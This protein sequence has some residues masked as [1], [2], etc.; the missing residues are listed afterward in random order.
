VERPW[1]L[2]VQLPDRQPEPVPHETE[3]YELFDQNNGSLLILGEP[4]SG[5]STLLM[6]LTRQLIQRAEGDPLVPIP[7][8]FNLS[9]WK[10]DQSLASWVEDELKSKYYVPRKVAQEWLENDE[11]ALMLDGLDEVK[12]DY[13]EDCVQAIHVF[14]EDHVV[15]LAVCSRREAYEDLSTRLKLR[16]AIQIQPLA[17]EQVNDY[18][19]ALG[20]KFEWVR[21]EVEHDQDLQE[22]LNTPLMLS[23]VTLANAGETTENWFQLDPSRSR[24]EI[25]I[26][27]YIQQML[28]RRGKDRF[29]TPEKT[30]H[31]IQWLAQ[32]MIEQGQTI[33]YLESVHRNLLPTDR[34]K[35]YHTLLTFV[36]FGLTAS[37]LFVWNSWD[38]F[39]H[40]QE[41]LFSIYGWIMYREFY[42]D[43]VYSLLILLVGV[44]IIGL[45]ISDLQEPVERLDWSWSNIRS[46]LRNI[47][48]N[49]FWVGLTFWLTYWLI[50]MLGAFLLIKDTPGYTFEGPILFFLYR[51]TTPSLIQS[52]SFGVMGGLIGGLFGGIDSILEGSAQIEKRSNPGDGLKVSLIIGLRVTLGITIAFVLIYLILVPGFALHWAIGILFGI[53][54]GLGFVLNHYILRLLLFQSGYLPWNITGFLNYCTERIFMRRVGGGYIFIHRTLMEHF[55]QMEEKD[56]LNLPET[57]NQDQR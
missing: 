6:E 10:P 38:Y 28:T 13:Q 34:Q 50:T 18:L 3:I 42:Y 51:L 27:T 23:I 19:Q 5:K 43:L 54:Y 55:A 30:L 11:L 46:G 32:Q 56:V 35:K 8:V 52:L 41:P 45:R 40:S 47:F 20:A 7:V 22:L 48:R 37:L 29:Y 14:Q 33:F 9:S 1:E 57:A 36:I 4:G 26:Q 21:Q 12:A 2:V 25:L 15:S 44:R 16:S 39:F 24:T 31:W 17:R 49:G 53:F